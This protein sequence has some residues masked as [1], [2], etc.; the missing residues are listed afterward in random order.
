MRWGHCV[1]LQRLDQHLLKTVEPL[2]LT[3]K[4]VFPAREVGFD[5]VYSALNLTWFMGKK[6]L[7]Q[8]SRL[9]LETWLILLIYSF[10]IF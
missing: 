8:R 6:P 7:H 5:S 1:G 9:R 2:F 3:Q 10:I 4:A